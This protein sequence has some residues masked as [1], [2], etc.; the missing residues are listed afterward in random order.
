MMKE[1]Y[2]R[3][4]LLQS[5]EALRH[6]VLRDAP[7]LDEKAVAAVLDEFEKLREQDPLAVLQDGSLEG[8]SGGG[9]LTPFKM[10][11]N[12]EIAMY[13]AQATGSCIVTDSIF[14]WRELKAA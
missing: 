5:R 3:S 11:P 8:G 6:Q 14:R 4:M 9:Q 12:F 2:K 1:E 13:L 7:T 10:A